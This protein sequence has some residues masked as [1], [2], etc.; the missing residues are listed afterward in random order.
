MKW[1]LKGVTGETY[2]I[3]TGSGLATQH[4][5][6]LKDARPLVESKLITGAGLSH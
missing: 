4:Y 2:D 3:W 1:G 5:L 6:E